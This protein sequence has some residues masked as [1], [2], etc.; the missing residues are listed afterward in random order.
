LNS[1]TEE[2]HSKLPMAARRSNAK[3]FD[4]DN[5]GLNVHDYYLHLKFVNKEMILLSWINFV[6][7]DIVDQSFSL[8]WHWC[9][10]WSEQKFAWFLKG[11]VGENSI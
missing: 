11:K 4:V 9:N 3:R 2:V 6:C 8:S 5:N 1:F 7:H 10:C